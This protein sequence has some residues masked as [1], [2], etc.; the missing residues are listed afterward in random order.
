MG[1]IYKITS[2]SNKIYV[3][4]T[5]NLAHRIAAHKCC[6]KKG[7]NIILHNSIRK[8]G[9][10]SHVLEVIE[11]VEDAF[12]D[13]REIYWIAE[14]ETYCYENPMGLNMT[15]GGEGQRS[16]WMHKTGL[17]KWFS[18][19]FTGEGNPFYGKKHTEETRKK[20]SE[21][22]KVRNR[23]SGTM[24]PKW[25]VEKGRLNVIKPV[26]C[27]DLNGEFICEYESA[28]KA[29]TVLNIN[30][31]GVTSVC[32]GNSTNA[33]GFIFRY[34]TSETPSKIDVG[35]LKNKTIKRPVFTLTDDYEIVCEHESAQEASEFWGI[36]KTTINR[37]AMYNWLKPIRT[38]H[39]FIYKD[40]YEGIFKEAS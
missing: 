4:K 8:Y 22:A 29:A 38:G 7:S 34:K 13:E 1:I 19:K 27:Y 26:V 10:D 25:G 39:V 31:S 12:M 5:Y 40:L 14:L 2:P 16:T 3:G 6:V 35:E 18:E 23:K 37:A 36:P 24:I 17:R 33:G 30:N 32:R 21:N 20:L 11:E 9:W 28:A 15:K